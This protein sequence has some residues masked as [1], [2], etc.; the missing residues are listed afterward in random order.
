[1]VSNVDRT[2]ALGEK[3]EGGSRSHKVHDGGRLLCSCFV[4]LDLA[5]WLQGLVS[6]RCEYI[7]RHVPRAA[8]Y[9]GIV[10][11]AAG[12]EPTTQAGLKRCHR[13][14]ETASQPSHGLRPRRHMRVSESQQERLSETTE[15][16]S[17][18]MRLRRMDPSRVVHRGFGARSSVCF[19]P[20]LG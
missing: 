10:N 15:C 9:D 7:G 17:K 16:L 19:F 2:L 11:L 3:T 12:K 8:G 13:R 20:Q 4:T 18:W 6:F 1:M 5:T 14:L